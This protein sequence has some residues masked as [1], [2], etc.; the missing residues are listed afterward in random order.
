[1]GRFNNGDSSFLYFLK[2]SL[3]NSD[4]EFAKSIL[5]IANAFLIVNSLGIYPQERRGWPPQ[6]IRFQLHSTNVRPN[7]RCRV[8][9]PI[10]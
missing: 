6:T 8:N 3:V 1:M 10:R 2:C 7:R 9:Y 4:V 5:F